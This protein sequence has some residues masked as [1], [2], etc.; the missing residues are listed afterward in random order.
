MKTLK[1][2]VIT[3]IAGSF[4][5]TS[6][7]GGVSEELKK[8][9]SAFETEWTKA[10][11][12]A[13]AFGASITEEDSAMAQM[14]PA[15][16]PDSLKMNATPVQLAVIDS[17]NTVCSGHTEKVAEIKATFDGFKASWDKDSKV[18]ADW[19]AKVEKGEVKEE[20]AKTELENWKKK[21]AAANT[22]IGEWQSAL[23]G[24]SSECSATCNAQK[25]AI[26]AIPATPVKEE[27]GKKKK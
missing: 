3:L 8:E 6:C 17:L 9:L 14:R 21:L 27:K 20:E 4:L 5:F 19:K 22:S 24:V 13:T 10:G 2:S 18:W 12:A 25:D 15:E 1:L 7:G 11:D 16:L 26:A 23:D